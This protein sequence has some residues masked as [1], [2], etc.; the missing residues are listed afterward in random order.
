MINAEIILK[1]Y[2]ESFKWLDLAAKQGFSQGKFDL[3]ILIYHK[4]GVPEK[5]R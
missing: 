4:K 1:D 3:E 2:E 5:I